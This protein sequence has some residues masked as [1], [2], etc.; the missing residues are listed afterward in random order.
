[1]PPASAGG[2]G[3]RYGDVPVAHGAG[4]RAGLLLQVQW[5]WRPHGQGWTVQPP[6][7]VAP[8]QHQTQL[9][10]AR[11]T[12]GGG[13]TR[14]S[15]P[16]S[17]PLVRRRHSEEELSPAGRA[18]RRVGRRQ[19]QQHAPD[20]L[21]LQCRRPGP[22]SAQTLVQVGR[23]EEGVGSQAH[24]QEALDQGGAKPTLERVETPSQRHEGQKVTRVGSMHLRA[25]G[26][27]GAAPSWPPEA[28]PLRTQ[29]PRSW[30]RPDPTGA[31]GSTGW[32]ALCFTVVMGP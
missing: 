21:A 13:L 11:W 25:P 4:P 8:W 18:R 19:W 30:S 29:Q 26:P 22:R 27:P 7:T 15:A 5:W 9:M 31:S 6:G 23:G 32:G 14:P 24:G 17:I 28:A 1:M 3:T 2:W 20:S 12:G 16:Q 10:S